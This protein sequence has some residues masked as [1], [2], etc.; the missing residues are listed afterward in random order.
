MSPSVSVVICAYTEERW[1]DLEAA[2]ESL[3]RQTT[4]LLEVILVADHNEALLDRARSVLPGVIAVENTESPGLSGAR[5][6]GVAASTGAIVAFL[7]DDAVAEPDWLERLAAHYADPNLIGVGGFVE[8]DWLEGRPRCFP[9]EFDWVVGCSYR[10]L[11]ELISRVRNPIGANMSFRAEVLHR[12]HGFTSGIG[13]VGKRP[14]G[15]EETEFCIRA[16]HQHPDGV[17]LYDPRARVHHRV[18]AERAQ[19]RY[20]RSRCYSEGLSKALVS[21]CAGATDALSEERSY[22][23]R[24]LPSGVWQGLMHALA[25]DAGGLG[26]ASAIVAGLAITSYGYGSGMLASRRSRNGG[27]GSR[28]LVSEPVPAAGD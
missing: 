2:V 18:P 27:A 16:A 24:T 6:S 8:A 1:G 23:R 4:A 9:R 17:I 25:G 3:R 20:F 11:P 26:R 28:D 13:R 22:V 5:N 7:D 21:G 10:G 14:V 19:W 12:T 15:C